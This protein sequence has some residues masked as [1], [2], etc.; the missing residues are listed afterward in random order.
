MFI[1]SK[2]MFSTVLALAL[3]LTALMPK[4]PGAVADEPQ[5]RHL[6]KAMTDY[7]GAQGA[8]SFD[9]DATLEVVTTDRQKLELAA[10][11]MVSLV[12]PDKI[13][14]TRSGG[15]VDIETVFDGRTLT[16]LGKNKNVYTQL[17]LSGSFDHL[18]N[19]LQNKYDRPL[20]AADLFLTNA[21]DELMA[22]VTD[23]KDLGSGVIGGIE[24]DYL[25]FRTKE[26]D[27]QIWIA[28]GTSPHPCRYVI[29]STRIADGPQ[30]GIQ[31]R[32]WRTGG[33]VATR[34]FAFKP[35]AGARRIDFDELKT[36]KDMGELP[37]NFTMGGK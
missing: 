24:C 21:Y 2:A 7:L 36:M 14:A 22:D 32:N 31:F 16:F 9:Y 28:Q 15:F 3:L 37:S 19:E 30:Y 4:S 33:E 25:A 23:V 27:W 26:V 6:L 17:E 5:A 1:Q 11:G 35:P 10:S 34:D 20:P 13:R 8:M 29:T 18:V 12:R